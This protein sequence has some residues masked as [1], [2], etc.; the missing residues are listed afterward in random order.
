[1][2]GEYLIFFPSNYLQNCLIKLAWTRPN[3][4]IQLYNFLGN[5]SNDTIP[6]NAE[7]IGVEIIAVSDP[8]GNGEGRLYSAAS[9]QGTFDVECY[10]YNGENYSDRLTWDTSEDYDGIT[11]F[12]IEGGTN[13]LARFS[14]ANRHYKNNTAGRDV[15]FG[16]SNDLSGLTWDPANQANFGF[17]L[18]WDNPDGG[19]VV[20]GAQRGIMMNV[21]YQIPSPPTENKVKIQ[22]SLSF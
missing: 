2:K 3:K 6:S 16:G 11:F 15:L 19:T 22:Q 17:S 8:D 7:I 13:N 10:L 5:D 4:L 12:N 1:M 21:I 14:G 20:A 9:N 18:V